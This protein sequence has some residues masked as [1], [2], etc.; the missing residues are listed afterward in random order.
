MPLSLTLVPLKFI[1]ILF[2]A[3]CL[4]AF[5]ELFRVFAFYRKYFQIFDL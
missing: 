2:R 3:V 4:E 1:V 5:A